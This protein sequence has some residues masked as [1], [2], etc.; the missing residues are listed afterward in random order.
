M[1]NQPLY[2]GMRTPEVYSLQITL[3]VHP[4]TG[5]FGP[6]TRAAVVKFQQANGIDPI[7]IVGPVTR[8]KL[9]ALVS[10]PVQP[11]LTAPVLLRIE[12]SSAP[13]GS[14]VS[15]I[16]SN[17]APQVNIQMGSLKGFP[18]ESH[19]G[20]TISVMVP[21]TAVP[22]QYRL[23]VG[24]GKAYSNQVA[25]WVIDPN[26]PV[27]LPAPKITSISPSGGGSGTTVTIH[28]TGFT[29]I[30]NTVYTGYSEIN[31][32]SSADGTTLT[33]TVSPPIPS[34]KNSPSFLPLWIYVENGN[35]LSSEMVFK[36]QP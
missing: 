3:E 7:G 23:S 6:I 29:D 18:A 30:D 1:F 26:T 8:A 20:S 22:G 16:G 31:R 36:Y 10:S 5:Y 4:A 14:I 27:K 33:F 13:A 35:G 32:L 11:P 28:G 25:L 21:A 2:Q 34:F 24:N 9:N 19:D 17:F 12:P 15:I